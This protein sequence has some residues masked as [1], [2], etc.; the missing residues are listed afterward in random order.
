VI[1]AETERQ[2]DHRRIERLCALAGVSRASYYRHWL[3]SR[4]REEE[5][6]LR[7]EIQRLSLAQRANGYRHGYRVITIQ[8]R[9]AGWA[10]NHK[11]VARIR[12]E[13]NLLCVPKQA[14]RPATTASRHGWR[15]WP[16]LACRLVPM[17]VNQLWVADITYIR[18]REEF[19]Y[20]AVVLDAFSRRVVGWAMAE[21]L[22][23]D[24]ALSA[25]E[26]AIGNRDVTPGGLVHHSDQGVQYA[27]G[28]YIARL[29]QAGIQPS[30]S[31]P[32]CPW[33][34]AMAES[35]MRTLKREEV[36][37]QAYRDR[38][39][40]EASIGAFIETVYNRQR[41]HSALTYLAPEAF[42]TMQVLMACPGPKSGVAAPVPAMAA[43]GAA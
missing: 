39:E 10:V 9:R 11:R 40:A 20:L 23:A 36:D 16:N 2:G 32:G 15:V 14:F 6:A 3:A 24:L 38:A 42:E 26:M 27:C 35:F 13:D 1:R 12:R 22:R 30:M 21:H 33:D 31:R 28:D 17:A 19:V 41:L 37:G 8:L 5:T 43:A 25:L 4:P 18:L 29:E 7:D 34:N